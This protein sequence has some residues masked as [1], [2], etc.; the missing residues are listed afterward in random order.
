MEKGRN[1]LGRWRMQMMGRIVLWTQGNQWC[2][3][4]A[5]ITHLVLEKLGERYKRIV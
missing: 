1:A 5:C 3:T 4:T 2:D